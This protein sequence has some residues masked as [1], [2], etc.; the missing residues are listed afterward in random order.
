MTFNLKQFQEGR[1]AEFRK[2]FTYKDYGDIGQEFLEWSGKTE[3]EDVI[4]WESQTISLLVERVAQEVLRLAE[5]GKVA[6]EAVKI[7]MAGS[8]YIFL[9]DLKLALK[10][11]G[12]LSLNQDQ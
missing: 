2:N 9:Y 5:E 3:P 12:L 8:D 10:K 7:N 11:A 6:K 1:E 4:K